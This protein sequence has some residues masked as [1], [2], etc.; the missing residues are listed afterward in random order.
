MIL[1]VQFSPLDVAHCRTLCEDQNYNFQPVLSMVWMQGAIYDKGV[2]HFTRDLPLTLSD[3]HG[4]QHDRARGVVRFDV[5][6]V[7]GL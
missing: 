5:M 1:E 7:V 3:D 4:N 6:V 2:W